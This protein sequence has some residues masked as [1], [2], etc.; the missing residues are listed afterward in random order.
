MSERTHIADQLKHVI[1]NYVNL[2][3]EDYFVL[4]DAINEFQRSCSN[5]VFC[6]SGIDVDTCSLR[7]AVVLSKE[8]EYCTSHKSESETNEPF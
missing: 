8:I 6:V 5:C 3:P 1:K 4:S 2:A 7:D